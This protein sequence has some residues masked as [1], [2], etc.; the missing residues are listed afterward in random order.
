MHL[1][2][3]KKHHIYGVIYSFFLLQS[4]LHHSKKKST[5]VLVEMK[6]PHKKK[7]AAIMMTNEGYGVRE[8]IGS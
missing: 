6:T 3:H 2:R 1:K 4:M 8:N 7:G 5:F